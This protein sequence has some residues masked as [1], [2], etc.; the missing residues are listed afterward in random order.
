MLRFNAVGRVSARTILLT[1]VLL[2]GFSVLVA[3]AAS[4]RGAEYWSCTDPDRKATDLVKTF[5]AVH[6]TKSGRFHAVLD[7]GIAD[8]GG[9]GVRHILAPAGFDEYGNP[10]RVHFGGYLS[11]WE[12][13]AIGNTLYFGRL[14]AQPDGNLRYAH[15]VPVYD[16]NSGHLLGV[17]HFV[18]VLDPDFTP[19]VVKTAFANPEDIRTLTGRYYKLE[20]WVQPDNWFNIVNG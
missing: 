15:K 10:G 16:N 14:H 1:A 8:R 11:D 2:F 7:C 17:Q 19:P 9:R 6:P 3:P 5:E 12:I 20:G 18:V 4:A 13:Y